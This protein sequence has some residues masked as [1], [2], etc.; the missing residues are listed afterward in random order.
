MPDRYSQS[1]GV[2]LNTVAEVS[3]AVGCGVTGA[4][5]W[6]VVVVVVASGTVCGVTADTGGRL[7]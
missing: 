1:V 3:A 5:G 4:G 7:L 6:L 2:P